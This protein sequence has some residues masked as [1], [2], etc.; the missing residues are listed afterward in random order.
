MTAGQAHESRSAIPNDFTSE[1]WA[2]FEEIINDVNEPWLKV[3]L[4][5]LLWLHKKTEKSS[6]HKHRYRTPN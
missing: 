1:Q 6:T 5:D 2:F 4:A 3:R